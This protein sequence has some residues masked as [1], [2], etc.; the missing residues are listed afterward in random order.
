MF[1]DYAT[2]WVEAFPIHETKAHVI[3]RIFV[4]EIVFHFSAPKKLIW[5]GQHLESDKPECI[6]CYQ[7]VETDPYFSNTFFMLFVSHS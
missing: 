5:S 7:I 1:L 3:A 4:D 6:T 2:K